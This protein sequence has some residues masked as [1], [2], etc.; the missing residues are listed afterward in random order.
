MEI[1]KPKPWHGLREFLKEYVI[2][3][4]GV[5]T[6]LAAEQAVEALHERGLA[7]EAREAIA[8]E[9]QD[10]VNRIA[11]RQ[12]QQSCVEQRLKEITGLL[13]DWAGGKAPPPGLFIGDP[14]DFPMVQQRWQANLNS[15]RFSRQS[16]AEQGVQAEFYTE[17]AILHEMGGREHYVWSELRTLELGPGVLRPDL[18][19]NLVAALQAARTDASDIGQ[20]G[21]DMLKTARR[22]GHTPKPTI[23]AAIA[24]TTCQSLVRRQ[25]PSAVSPG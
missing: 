3:V 10:N 16:N 17:L 2:I 4:I 8:A 5:L 6:A 22:A 20:L 9:M 11:F 23:V 13:A 24:P 25:A 15:G 7:R 1:H 14:G 21:Q 19:P 12:A 18:R